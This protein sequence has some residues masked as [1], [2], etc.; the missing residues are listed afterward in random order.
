MAKIYRVKQKIIK[1]IVET[2]LLKNSFEI[3]DIPNTA[4]S[5]IKRLN[6][7]VNS[8][9]NLFENRLNISAFKVYE[10]PG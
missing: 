2:F 5:E 1:T 4:L 9:S 7:W 6:K 3:L 8:N 10:I